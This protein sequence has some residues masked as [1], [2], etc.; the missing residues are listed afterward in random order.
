MRCH[1][2]NVT[3]YRTPDAGSSTREE[4]SRDAMSKVFTRW[5]VLPYE[6]VM[7]QG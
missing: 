5:F 2:M 1:T 3:E 4:P 7:N 6:N